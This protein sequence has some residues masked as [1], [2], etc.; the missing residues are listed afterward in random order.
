MLEDI[1]EEEEP[2]VKSQKEVQ[3]DI[4]IANL[5]D[6]NL[7]SQQDKPQEEASPPEE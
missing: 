1:D 3:D 2:L 5:E 4:D 6:D 7:L